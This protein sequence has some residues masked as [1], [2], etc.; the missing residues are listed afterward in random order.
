[1]TC[2]SR[3]RALAAQRDATLW[4]NYLIAV[5]TNPPG[6]KPSLIRAEA[7]EKLGADLLQTV[8]ASKWK[9]NAFL[10]NLVAISHWLI[11]LLKYH[12]RCRFW[13]TNHDLSLFVQHLRL[14]LA[15]SFC[16]CQLPFGYA[17]LP[18]AFHV[19]GIA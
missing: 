14:I 19:L 9:T 4:L 18:L 6:H 7:L 10:S 17:G 5:F 15:L 3:P 16:L 12:H 13:N 2:C 1:M 11:F 8:S